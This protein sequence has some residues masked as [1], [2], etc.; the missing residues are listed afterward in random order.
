MAGSGGFTGSMALASANLLRRAS[1]SLQS[2]TE[3]D[4][5]AGV[6]HG[7][8]GSK[9]ENKGGATVFYKNRSHVNFQSENTLSTKGM[10]LS[11]S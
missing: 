9:G 5:E 3:G 10:A 6:S 2:M 7:E 4:T 8:S 1:E 11:Y